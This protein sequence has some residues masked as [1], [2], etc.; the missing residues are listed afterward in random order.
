MAIYSEIAM[1]PFR[2]AP[3]FRYA[4]LS[5]TPGGAHPSA[6][7]VGSFGDVADLAVGSDCQGAG[8]AKPGSIG[9]SI[10]VAP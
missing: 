1:L 9:S 7:D 4:P 3:S 2:Y 5:A 10:W 6:R 8:G